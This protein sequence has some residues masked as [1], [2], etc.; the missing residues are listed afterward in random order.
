ME[1][2]K[3]LER[4]CSWDIYG[5]PKE[6][7]CVQAENLIGWEAVGKKYTQR[8]VVFFQT[9]KPTLA[10]WLALPLGLEPRTL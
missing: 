5:S 7:C 6:L 2:E 1:T 10:D 8:V 3:K 4:A 9:K